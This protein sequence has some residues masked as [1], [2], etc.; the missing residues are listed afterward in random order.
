MK[1]LVTGGVGLIGH[2]VVIKLKELGH[3]VAIVDNL[4]NYGVIDQKELDHLRTQR[5]DKMNMDVNS[6]YQVDISDASVDSIFDYEQPDIVI[7]M[8]SF[9]RQKLVALNPMLAT[10]TM[11]DGLTNIL[12]CSIKHN[13]P[14]FVYISSS[15]VYGTFPDN[16]TED[17]PCNSEGQ[18]GVFKYMGEKL[19][20][21]YERINEQFKSII[22][23]PSAV[24]GE[25]DISDRIL[26]SFM[27]KALN[28]LELK[29]HGKNEKLDFTYVEDAANGIIKASLCENA[30]GGVYN[31]TKGSSHTLYEVAQM[32]VK[33]VGR[34][35]ISAKERLSGY[36]SRGALDISRA[37]KSFGYDPKIDVEEG[38]RKFYDWMKNDDFWKI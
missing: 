29:V 1:I 12:E 35:T 25:T 26:S 9:P 24:Y 37:R 17:T 16:I 32:V 8:A 27:I 4:T 33:L 13:V 21:E 6:I 28:G 10:K 23:R 19:V 5:F 7:H 14:K 38:I 30:Y 18:Y 34:G 15:M 20:K 3:E 2:N 36:P 31:M 11:C 22:I